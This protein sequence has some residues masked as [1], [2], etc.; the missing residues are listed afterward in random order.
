MKTK[1]VGIEVSARHVHLCQADVDRLFG[2]GYELTNHHDIPV[3]FV[4]NEKLAL[5]GPK[6]T[7]EKVTILG[8]VRKETQ[9][10]ISLTDA[11][12][13]GVDAKIRMSGDLDGTCGIQIK[14]PDT[15][16]VIEIDHGVI[17]A[18]RH[19]HCGNDDA[20]EL[21]LENNDV[22]KLS[23]KN[24]MERSLVFDDVVVRVGGPKSVV[25]IDTDEGNACGI[26]RA[27]VCTVIVEK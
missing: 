25:H 11:I 9:V 5:I 27:G 7:I 20:A 4:A 18:K 22:V 10:E 6:R 17:V 12:A 16:N 3:G 21:G 26:A 8:P 1:E 24:D 2:E 23:V 15:G 14:S 13:L 19:L